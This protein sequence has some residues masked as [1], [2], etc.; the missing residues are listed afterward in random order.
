MTARC[1]GRRLRKAFIVQARRAKALRV[2]VSRRPY[3]IKKDTRRSGG[4]RVC[5]RVLPRLW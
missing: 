3:T 5:T 1:A 4:R 2:F